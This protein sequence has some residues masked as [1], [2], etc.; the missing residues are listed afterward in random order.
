MRSP[1]PEF[2]PYQPS[3]EAD[4][5]LYE[6]WLRMLQLGELQQT[7]GASAAALSQFF[8]YF[9][10][11]GR[12][13]A[14]ALQ[15]DGRMGLAF[16]IVPMMQA[17]FVTVWLCP[18]WRGTARGKIALEVAYE[19]ALSQRP[20]LLG[21]TRQERLLGIHARWGYRVFGRLPGVFDGHDGWVVVLTEDAYYAAKAAGRPRQRREDGRWARVAD[22]VRSTA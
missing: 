4:C 11:G 17:S 2:H 6:W 9:S 15:D 19:A 12:F 13:L 1:P 7:F 22:P 14:Y 20:L 16:L 10:G 21:I 3:V 18:E 8:A 5:V